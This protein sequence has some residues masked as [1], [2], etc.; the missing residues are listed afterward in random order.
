MATMSLL[1]DFTWA[2]LANY[3]QFSKAQSRRIAPASGGFELSKGNFR[4]R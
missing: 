1:S 3:G 4:L 2:P